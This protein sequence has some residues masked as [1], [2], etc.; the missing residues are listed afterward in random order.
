MDMACFF[1]KSNS[2]DS[3]KKLGSLLVLIVALLVAGASFAAVNC[4]SMK[5]VSI[6]SNEGISSG[7]QV[8]F[9]NV[10]TTG[11]CNNGT[12]DLMAV[13]A[14]Q[15]FPLPANNPDKT[16]A[17]L[18]TGMSLNKTFVLWVENDLSGIISVSLEDQ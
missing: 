10:G 5:A 14:T 12:T 2:E 7:G 8:I 15:T 11:T 16:M 9:K 17:L 6:I 3:M 18:L 13:N 1:N 4:Q